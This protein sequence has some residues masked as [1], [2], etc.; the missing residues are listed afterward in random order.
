MSFYGKLP[1]VIYIDEYKCPFNKDMPYSVWRYYGNRAFEYFPIY[2]LEILAPVNLSTYKA[3]I[4]SGAD[5]VYFG[6]GTLNARAGAENFS[7][8]KQIVSYCH[9][10]GVKAYLALNVM[11]KERELEEAKLIVKQAEEAKIDAFII[12]DFALLPIIRRY[13][14]ARVHLSTQAGIHNV[15]GA[16]FAL[17]CGFDRIILSREASLEDIKEIL[18][19]VDIEVEVFGH[20][21]LCSG[22]SGACLFSSMLTGK[23]GN[24]GRCLQFCR[25]NFTSFINGKKAK[26]GY[27][28]SA[29]DICTADNIGVLQNLGVTSL[30]I[31]GR[32]K[33]EDYVDGVTSVYRMVRDGMEFTEEMSDALKALF[34]RGNFTLPYWYSADNIIYTKKPNHIGLKVGKVF[35]VITKNL[36]LVESDKKI[37]KGDCFKAMRGE[38]EIGGLEAT[39][40]KRKIDDRTYYVCYSRCAACRGDEIF[41]TKSCAVLEEDKKAIMQICVRIV[42][43]EPI[44]VYAT[45]RGKLVEYT[46]EIALEAVS[47][48]LSAAD[49][50]NQFSKTGETEFDFL[51][52]SVQTD[53]AFLTKKRLNE[54][55]REIISLMEEKLVNEYVRPESKTYSYPKE[56]P[57]I[58]GNFAS[59]DDVNIG[60][61]LKKKFRNIVFSP[62]NFDII[63]FNAAYRDLKTADNNVFIKFPIFIP[64]KATEKVESILGIFDGVIADNPGIFYLGKKL[65]KLTVAGWTLNIAN[66]KNPL[67][68]T[69]DQ[70]IVS[71]ELNYGELKKFKGLTVYAYG[72]IPL[73]YLNHCPR[74]VSGIS[75]KD[76]STVKTIVYRDE[77]GE[78]PIRKKTVANYCQHELLNSEIT[79][80]IG[81]I[82]GMNLYYDFCD[83]NYNQIEKIL[84][85][86]TEGL[87]GGN[88]NRLHLS[89]GVE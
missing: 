56:Q 42:G 40:E 88:Y 72:R 2:R 70:V 54:L 46:G 71:A 65:G 30:K 27:L 20:G 47:M 67:L 79:D 8:L 10:H 43:G 16:E 69:A 68:K 89:R 18:E 74:K 39:G 61:K 51:F 64:A 80:I 12:S 25:R 52:C 1:E 48:P 38:T 77:K 45:C 55:R 14:S 73:M 35:S 62:Q 7:D 66:T 84:G 34:N 57:K 4:R 50:K 9:I 19:K 28:L 86:R 26:V 23:S 81:K 32:L 41:L 17:K 6:Y 63:D 21:A 33:S 44:K 13:S 53:N 82:E 37:G 15:Y 11:I 58:N 76:C 60:K 83:C 22:F 3:A 31:E 29:K 75:C 24:R 49:I 36:V 87:N 85:D 5:A 78:Y 59:F